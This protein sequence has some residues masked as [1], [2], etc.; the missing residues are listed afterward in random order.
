MNFNIEFTNSTVRESLCPLSSLRYLYLTFT[1]ANFVLGERISTLTEIREL[2]PGSLH[3][4]TKTLGQ[5]MKWGKEGVVATSVDLEGIL[6]QQFR[7][8]VRRAR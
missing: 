4:H 6:R 5:M 8:R 3:L 2:V 7:R 1:V